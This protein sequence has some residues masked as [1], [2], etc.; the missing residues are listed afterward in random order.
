M[1]SPKKLRLVRRIKQYSDASIFYAAYAAGYQNRGQGSNLYL[2]DL[3]RC[4]LVRIL[5]TLQANMEVS[6]DELR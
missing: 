2:G 1:K 6:F 5:N 3:P 4:D